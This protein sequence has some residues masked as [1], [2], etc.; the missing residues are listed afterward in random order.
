MAYLGF[1]ATAVAPAS[2]F[3]ALPAGEYAVIITSTEMATTKRG[4]GQMLK[5]TLEVIEGQH[6]GRLLWSRINLVNTNPKAVEIAQ[7]ELSAICHAIGKPYIK[8]SDELCNFPLR[9]KVVYVPARDQYAESNDVK[10]WKAYNS[11]PSA[12][13]ASAF[14]TVPAAPV[15]TAAPSPAAAQKDSKTPP[16]KRAAA[17][18][19]APA[20]SIDADI[21]F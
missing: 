21:S 17:A 10:A 12:S 9:V 19:A 2:D 16:W 1:D 3:S 8:D 14:K 5:L 18:P 4:D 15:T 6:K 20:D 11:A 7:R 13:P